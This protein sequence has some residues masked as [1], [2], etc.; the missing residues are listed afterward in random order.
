[1]DELNQIIQ[2]I[3]HIRQLFP[4][5]SISQLEKLIFELCFP[6]RNQVFSKNDHD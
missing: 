5:D 1:M 2:L 4:P 3:Y 6:D